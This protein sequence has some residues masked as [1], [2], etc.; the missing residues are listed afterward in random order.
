[1]PQCVRSEIAAHQSA[2]QRVRQLAERLVAAS[3]Q[4]PQLVHQVETQVVNLNDSYAALQ[5]TAEQIKAS[6]CY[7]S[8]CCTSLS[9]Y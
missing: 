4:L 5:G 3:A 1:M 8:V 9:K 7:T 2:V 6:V